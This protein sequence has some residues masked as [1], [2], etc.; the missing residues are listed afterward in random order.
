MADATYQVGD[1]RPIASRKR[2][3]FI[4]MAHFLA[5]RGISANA[6]SVIGMLCG[7][8]AGVTLALTAHFTGVEQRVAWLAAAALIQLRLLANMLDG[9][10]AVESGQASP[11]GEL[12]NE[13]PDRISDAVILIGAGYA[14]GADP[15]LGY[16]AAT[17][18]VF[19]AYVRAEAKVA[20]APQDFCGPM[21]KQQRM[22]TVIFV[23][24]YSAVAPAV[25]QPLWRNRW[26]L[27]ALAL[28]VIILG[29]L[30]TAAR[31]IVRAARCLKRTASP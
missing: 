21:A 10:V 16:I 1:R 22:A 18:A 29:G 20:G 30:F 11:V 2:R 4:A 8:A 13:I 19:V 3:V 25:G 15:I 9:M 14:A 27:I 17:V 28:I 7:I 24:L 26:G 5:R 23:A 31:R 12:Y 6:I